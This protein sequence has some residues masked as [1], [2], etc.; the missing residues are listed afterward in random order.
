MRASGTLVLLLLAA[1]AR[2]ADAPV[3][4]SDSIAAARKDLAAIKG[5]TGQQDPSSALPSLDMKDL[6]PMPGSAPSVSPSLLLLDKDSALDPAKKK[7]GT[8]NWLVDA[9]DKNSDRSQASRSREKDDILKGDPDLLRGGEKLDP[10]EEKDPKSLD[11]ARDR[12]ASKEAAETAYNPLDSFMSGWISTR[13]HDLLLP[14]SKGEGPGGADLSKVR[15]ESLPGLETGQPVG[16]ENL[17]PAMDASALGDSH[18]PNPYMA[19]LQLEPAAPIRTF[20]APELPGF[21]PDPLPDASRGI[22]SSGVDPRPFDSSRGA[23]P[24]FAQPSDDDKYFRQMKR[25]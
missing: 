18:G 6:S 25:F 8:G 13:D 11:E 19:L 20:A 24:D 21:G 16:A 9:M 2:G 5:P 23:V 17:L 7:K 22:S 15:V 12:A 4:D 1:S 10:L 14:S 3:S